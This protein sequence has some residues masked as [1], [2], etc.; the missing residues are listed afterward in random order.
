MVDIKP[1]GAASKAGVKRSSWLVGLNGENIT[2]LT[3]KEALSRIER[4][5]RPLHLKLIVVSASDYKMLRKQLSM[6]IRQ[7]KSER[8]VPEQDRMSFRVFQG[9]IHQAIL[10]FPMEICC[11]I[12]RYLTM[13]DLETYEHSLSTDNESRDAFLTR[14]LP[15]CSVEAILNTSAQ[16]VQQQGP[17]RAEMSA[18]RRYLLNLFG[19]IH[20]HDDKGENV[21][22]R[23]IYILGSLGK[24]I[25]Q[26]YPQQNSREE[27][28]RASSN[29]HEARKTRYLLLIALILYVL[30][31]LAIIENHATWDAMVHCLRELIQAM[32]DDQVDTMI[33]PLISRLSTSSSPTAR[34]VPIAI[35]SDVYPRAS[36]DVLVQLRGMVDRLAL[37]D[38]PLVRRAVTSILAQLAR[39]VGSYKLEWIVHLLEKATS[40]NHDIVRTFA[41]KS[42]LQVANILGA[43]LVESD[44][45]AMVAEMKPL[46]PSLRLLYCQMVPLVNSYVCDTSWQVR[47]EAARMLPSLCLIFGKEYARMSLWITSSESFAIQ[48]WK[49]VKLAWRSRTI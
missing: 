39:V 3:H 44:T 32:S 24:R 38:N 30:E 19:T 49:C 13:D 16:R 14:I 23:T 4:A 17:A 41:V 31:S 35:L 25:A 11:G 10:H 48:Q 47:V 12:F 8:P 7:P 5:E 29:S 45:K 21:V 22:I 6:N 28:D 37:D 43:V 36:G 15:N 33:I 34:I 42:Y 40:D 27:H 9:K 26:L 1:T 46:D 20:S 2:N 18:E